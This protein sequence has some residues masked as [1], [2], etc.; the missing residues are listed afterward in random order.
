MHFR[1]ASL[2]LWTLFPLFVF[3][4]VTN[5][6]SYGVG[7]QS[8][9]ACGVSLS[10]LA[11]FCK[12]KGYACF[13][14][15]E[16]GIATMAGCLAYDHKN[17]TGIKY[18][19]GYCAENYETELT[20]EKIEEG[21]KYYLESAIPASEME[22][23]NITVPVK[24]PLKINE[25]SIKLFEKS[26]KVFLGNYDHSLYYGAGCL[27]YWGL[28]IIIAMIFN[29][30]SILFPNLKYTFDGKFSRA[31]RKYL[32]LPALGKTKRAESQ[33]FMYVLEFLVPSRLETLVVF[34]FFWLCFIVNATEIYYVK[35]DPLFDTRLQAINRFV[36]DRTGIICT[37]LTPLLVLFGGRNNFVQLLTRWKYSTVMVYHRWIARLVVLMAFIH[38]LC[39]TV[40]FIQRSDYSE[41]MAENYL[42]WGVVAT[43]C[44]ALLCFQGLLFLRRNWYEMFLVLHILLAV[45]FLVG[46]YY[47]IW[48][49]GYVQLVYPCFAVWG[50]DRFMRLVRLFIF[51]FPVATVSLVANETITVRVKKPTYW[52]VTPGGHAWLYIAGGWYFW[53]S[54]PFTLVDRNDGTI[55]FYC[56]VKHGVTNN[57]AKK[58]ANIPGR[59]MQM[60]VGVEGPYGETKPIKGHSNVVFVAGGSGI[61]GIY[62]EAVDLARKGAS[63]KQAIKLIWIIRE[64]KSLA[65]FWEELQA[66]KD[67]KIDTTI[68][69]TR[70]DILEG[71]D[72]FQSLVTADSNSDKYEGKDNLRIWD[73]LESE[74]PHIQILE[75][76][77]CL[78]GIIVSEIAEAANS[79][80]FISCGHP[81]MVDDIRYNVVQQIDKS[82][83]RVDFYDALEVWA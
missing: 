20:Q 21:Y 2:V 13:C 4:K 49:L 67:T 68:Y 22:N 41:S 56:K 34:F 82:Q 62:C 51:G 38:S 14:S 25:T 74:L 17:K 83:K 11:K 6:E 23:F 75:G 32:T 36:G 59:S 63:N 7:G 46:L 29:W 24:V 48:E 58:L 42:I 78:E 26:Y 3:G 27:G 61:P 35:N 72:E 44:G 65:W 43:T 70:P 28:I 80:A 71:T 54:H 1:L 57:L 19:R 64:L 66:L 9:L 39:Y 10:R 12:L 60:R 47:H 37:V 77:P 81:A 18:W 31:W 76:R 33:R 79:I 5:Y 50:F 55:I 52:K 73:Q 45:F 69:V 8:F 15:S 16:I 30:S 53:Q 40:L